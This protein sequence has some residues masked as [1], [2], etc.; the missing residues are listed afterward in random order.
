MPVER[1]DASS[2]SATTC[3]PI[4][5]QNQLAFVDDIAKG[6][7]NSSTPSAMPI[8]VSIGMMPIDASGMP[9]ARPMA[10]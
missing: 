6:G 7:T 8:C 5:A 3:A 2:A 10:G 4:S 1:D 9:N